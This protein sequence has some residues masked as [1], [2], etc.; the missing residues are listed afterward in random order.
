[1]ELPEMVK[2][3]GVD[4]TDLEL[5]EGQYPILEGCSYNSYVILDE[6]VC[7]MDT[8]DDRKT[9]E[10]LANV[11]QTLNGRTPDYI[12]VLHCEPDH[13]G[14]VVEAV[15]AYPAATIVCSAKAQQFLL[16]FHPTLKLDGKVQVIKEGDELVLG[17]HVLTFVA[18]PFVHWPE[19]M[20]AYEKTDGIL[21]SA[22]GFGKFGA[23]QNETDDWAT[24]ARRY[25]FNICGK[26]GTQVQNVLKKAAA[27]N[28]NVICPLHG[29]VLTSNIGYYVGLYDTWSSYKA[30]TDG[31][32][33]A[34]CT[35]HGGTEDAA[36]V[37]VEAFER[38]GRKVVARNLGLAD[39]SECVSLAF[40]YS[41]MVLC[42]PTYDAAVMPVMAD[43]LH[44]LSAKN[45]QKRTVA[46]VE[47]GTWAP[48][49]ARTMTKII[50][51]M[52]DVAIDETI[53]SIRSRMTP[54]NVSA[55]H[56]LAER[57]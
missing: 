29:P 25:Y 50:E 41:K 43:F 19:V 33:V 21:F 49:A 51:T 39:M 42:A 44:H 57:F 5:F 38:Q 7:V 1:M 6:K 4:D 30:E 28:I 12:V 48:Q 24:E 2:Y 16:Q 37:L 45:F 11:R 15:T 47:N 9:D 8:V 13:A 14:S 18:A 17:K 20:M 27:L 36:K 35:L 26:Y 55:L 46:L 56:A 34:Y 40:E 54:E 10:W 23:L 22:D 52:N 32:F 53:V 31:V 3:V